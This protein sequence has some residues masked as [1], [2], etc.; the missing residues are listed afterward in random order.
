MDELEF[1][2]SDTSFGTWLTLYLKYRCCH[3]R[4]S[5]NEN[6]SSNTFVFDDDQNG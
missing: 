4:T 6:G 2:I 1:L 3:Q 5:I